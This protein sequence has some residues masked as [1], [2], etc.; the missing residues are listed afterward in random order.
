[1]QARGYRRMKQNSVCMGTQ[2]N[3]VLVSKLHSEL[4]K[5]VMKNI[6]LSLRN[7]DSAKERTFS[8]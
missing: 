5:S 6:Q 7:F 2:H 3:T 4:K 8:P 1:M